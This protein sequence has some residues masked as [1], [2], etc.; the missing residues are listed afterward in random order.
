M[1][2]KVFIIEKVRSIFSTN[3]T[4]KYKDLS[5]PIYY[6][7]K[8][9]KIRH[10]LLNLVSVSLFSY[11]VYQQL[12]LSE[13]KPTSTAL[14]LVNKSIMVPKEI[15]EDVLVRVNKFIHLVILLF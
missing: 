1:Q 15:I 6:I 3:N 2:K 5:S 4:L 11:S 7:I 12:N 13:F 10:V 9:H 8:D 14:L